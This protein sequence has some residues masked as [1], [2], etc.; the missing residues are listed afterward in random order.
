MKRAEAYIYMIKI[1]IKRNLQY[2][3][4]LFT[5]LIGTLIGYLG[6]LFIYYIMFY[7]FD[8]LNGWKFKEMLF[9]YSFAGISISLS[10]LLFKHFTL[11]DNE[12]IK[13]TFDYFL[14]RPISPFVNYLMTQ[15]DFVQFLSFIVSSIVF[16]YASMI[17]GIDWSLNKV[18]V[19][20]F[21]MVGAFLVSSGTYILIGTIAFW[22]KKSSEL[23][24]CLLWPLQYLSYLPINI[25]P[26]V[27]QSIF[28][29]VIPLGFV[30]FY[31]STM[32]LKLDEVYWGSQKL[33]ECTLIVGILYFIVCKYWWNFSLKQYEG[34]GS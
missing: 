13:G 7:N 10:S 5:E 3:V 15:F 29:F 16:V 33:G 34:A 21:C 8:S 2:K 19:L 24:D 32:F 30:S 28:T 14:V 18:V 1:D 20:F 31:P 17:N 4:S 11:L 23:Y 6:N 22:T 27:I 12:I 25:F 9:I 26:T